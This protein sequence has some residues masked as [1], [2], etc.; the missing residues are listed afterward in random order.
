MKLEYDAKVDAAYVKLSSAAIAG[1]EQLRP[2]IVLDYDSY[3]RVVGIEIL[4]ARKQ[5]PNIN[6]DQFEL[7]TA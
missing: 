7:E 1:S 5:R 3:N 4:N 2:G 6:L